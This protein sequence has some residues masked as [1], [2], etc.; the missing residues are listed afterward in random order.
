MR[1]AHL[2]G[3]CALRRGGGP[4]CSRAGTRCSEHHATRV[5]GVVVAVGDLAAEWESEW[6]RD[7]E[8]VARCGWTSRRAMAPSL[9][10]PITMEK[11]FPPATSNAT[12]DRACGSDFRR[13]ARS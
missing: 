9:S 8:C 2:G 12:G 1:E 11:G 7:L 5:G 13:E 6:D 3:V 4:R 10:S